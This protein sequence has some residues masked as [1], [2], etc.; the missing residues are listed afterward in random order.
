[1]KGDPHRV[2]RRKPSGLHADHAN[3]KMA[4]AKSEIHGMGNGSHRVSDKRILWKDV[5]RSHSNDALPFALETDLLLKEEFAGN[6]LQYGEL[7]AWRTRGADE[8][9]AA[10]YAESPV[11]NCGVDSDSPLNFTPPPESDGDDA[12]ATPPRFG[13]VSLHMLATGMWDTLGKEG[14]AAFSAVAARRDRL[15]SVLRP[16]Q[17][18]PDSDS[19]YWDEPPRYSDEPPQAFWDDGPSQG[20][21]DVST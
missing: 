11:A 10:P 8:G 7:P 14:D 15:P 2:E 3:A 12:A 4:S 13:P 5:E 20:A 1:M 19:G 6:H 9:R 21:Y 17:S 16:R 18:S